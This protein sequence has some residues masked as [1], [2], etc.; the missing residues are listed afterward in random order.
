VPDAL[1]LG[2][3]V[4]QEAVLDTVEVMVALREGV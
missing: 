2:V 4:Y 1:A 3:S